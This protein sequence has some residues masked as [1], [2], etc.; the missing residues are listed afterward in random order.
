MFLLFKFHKIQATSFGI[1]PSSGPSEN[2]RISLK[3]KMLCCYIDIQFL[4]LFSLMGSHFTI[5]DRFLTIYRLVFM[6]CNA[7][8][9]CRRHESQ[10]VQ[11]QNCCFYITVCFYFC[12]LQ[13]RM[14]LIQFRSCCG[15]LFLDLAVYCDVFLLFLVGS[16]DRECDIDSFF[17]LLSHT[18]C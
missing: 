1:L 10:F 3:I 7:T 17:L 12:V 13:C 15:D 2:Q 16:Y 6:L 18:V 9:T 11:S 14:S 8:C 5:V 4:L